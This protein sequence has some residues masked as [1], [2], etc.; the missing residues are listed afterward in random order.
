MGSVFDYSILD[1]IEK[2]GKVLNGT[3]EEFKRLLHYA[4]V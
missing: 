1:L 2:H 4:T 3:E